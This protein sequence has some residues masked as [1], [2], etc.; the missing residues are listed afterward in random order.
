MD[1]LVHIHTQVMSKLTAVSVA[2][3]IIMEEQQLAVGQQ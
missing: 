1:R 3:R 2:H